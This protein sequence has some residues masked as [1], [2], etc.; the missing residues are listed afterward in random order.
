VACV[1]VPTKT[2]KR[3]R[4]R[5]F[6]RMRNDLDQLCYLKYSGRQ[7]HSSSIAIGLAEFD[8]NSSYAATMYWVINFVP[9]VAITISLS[10]S[11]FIQ[12]ETFGSCQEGCQ[13]RNVA[14]Y[15]SDPI[16]WTVSEKGNGIAHTG[17]QDKFFGIFL[18]QCPQ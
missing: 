5:P 8:I 10:R 11:I 1:Q 4:K 15:L 13:T 17:T 18:A 2:P 6:A 16:H 7:S 9:Y 14:S 3:F 12:L